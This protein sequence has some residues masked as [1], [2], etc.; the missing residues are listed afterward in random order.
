MCFKAV[1]IAGDSEAE[2]VRNNS[3]DLE[4]VILTPSRKNETKKT[5]SQSK[6]PVESTPSSAQSRDIS[7]TP[8]SLQ[9]LKSPLSPAP[10]STPSTAPHPTPANAS[11]SS[12][13]TPTA[14]TTPAST[15][16]PA[17]LGTPVTPSTPASQVKTPKKRGRPVG[18]RKDPSKIDPDSPAAKK[19]KERKPKSSKK[20]PAVTDN[21]NG[22]TL[23]CVTLREPHDGVFSPAKSSD[24]NK[25]EVDVTTIKQPPHDI[26]NNLPPKKFFK[27]KAA[28]KE[29]VQ[30]N[31][32]RVSP[33]PN[34][35][36]ERTNFRKWLD[37]KLSPIKGVTSLN[38]EP[39]ITNG[40][41][42]EGNDN[43]YFA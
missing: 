41:E 31:D 29:N 7:S 15:S 19:A 26:P 11:S 8:Q 42:S 12:L 27:S 4:P 39:P 20:A 17:S 40:T 24:D 18:W 9:T 3:N 16:T 6:A 14:V 36:N 32:A 22:G 30:A 1:I 34:P 21:G 33:P 37:D 5:Q 28:Q 35:E 43:S 2:S 38:V 23:D 25:M 10:P 13:L